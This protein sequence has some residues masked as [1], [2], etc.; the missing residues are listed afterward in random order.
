MDILR[1]GKIF[2]HGLNKRMWVP[3]R[4]YMKQNFIRWV[5]AGLMVVTGV[6]CTTAYD[7]YGRPQQV[8]DPG[9]AVLGVAAAGLAGYALANRNDHG[10]RGRSY[11]YGRSYS[12]YCAPRYSHHSHGHHGW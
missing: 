9:V 8:V 2:L 10:Y 7:A 5:A 3:V 4:P 1:S 6:S 11:G 12:N